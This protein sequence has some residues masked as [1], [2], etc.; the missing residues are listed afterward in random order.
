[1]KNKFECEYC[2][3]VFTT[4]YGLTKHENKTLSCLNDYYATLTNKITKTGF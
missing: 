1:M 2:K 3:K 4:K